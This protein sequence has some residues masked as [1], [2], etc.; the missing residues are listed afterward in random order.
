[1]LELRDSALAVMACGLLEV[2]AMAVTMLPTSSRSLARAAD[3]PRFLETL[4][5]RVLELVVLSVESIRE[6]FARPTVH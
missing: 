2:D 1:M 4:M 5:G 6:R 3:H